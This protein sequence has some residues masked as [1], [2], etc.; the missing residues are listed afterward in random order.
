MVVL[1]ADVFLGEPMTR[2]KV[3]AIVMAFVGTVII[4]Y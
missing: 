3:L 4:F 1:L 2:L